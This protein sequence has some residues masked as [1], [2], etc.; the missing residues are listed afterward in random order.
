LCYDCVRKLF[1]TWNSAD[2]H[3]NDEE[4]KKEA[5]YKGRGKDWAYVIDINYEGKY[6][7]SCFPGWNSVINLLVLVLDKHI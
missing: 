7:A 6:E 3:I 5:L 2:V 4:R 1:N